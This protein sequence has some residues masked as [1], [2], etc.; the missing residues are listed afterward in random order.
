M[1]LRI[2]RHLFAQTKSF[3]LCLR[4]LQLQFFCIHSP[5]SHSFFGCAQGKECT[6]WFA[7][8]IRH[9]FIVVSWK[10]S[11]YLFTFFE[12]NVNKHLC[13]YLLRQ[14]I[15]LQRDLQR[16]VTLTA[17]RHNEKKSVCL[18]CSNWQNIGDWKTLNGETIKTFVWYV[19]QRT[20]KVEIYT[21][22][23]IHG[24]EAFAIVNV[25]LLIFWK[26]ILR[27]VST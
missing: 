27:V 10:W 18:R 5:V 13:V 23:Q 14:C 22:K 4:C 16:Y 3:P 2:C 1:F 21:Q 19:Q 8:W 25:Y 15:N 9:T 7:T 17:E 26:W 24:I 11:I 6:H 12:Q 20:T